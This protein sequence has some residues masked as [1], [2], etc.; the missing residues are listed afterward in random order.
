MRKRRD[1]NL[2]NFSFV[3]ILAT[4]VGVLLFILLMA[5][6]NQSGLAAHT[7]WTQQLEDAKAEARAATRA[8]RDAQA[9]YASARER[10]RQASTRTRPQAAALAR[11]AQRAADD[12]ARRAAANEQTRKRILA[13][14]RSLRQ[15][16]ADIVRLQK[17]TARPTQG[18]RLMLPVA[19]KATNKTAVHVD[20]Q[21]QGLV[22]IGSKVDAGRASRTL[23]PASRI[24][25]PRS[26]FGSL[27]DAMRPADQSGSG[28]ERVLVLWI[29]PDG[30]PTA[31]RAL[32]A[33]RRARVPVGWE[34]ADADWT[35]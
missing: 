14:K 32:R 7:F 23:C 31:D 34:P 12:N 13:L 33:A 18:K 9:N 19:D 5:I 22:I 28:P 1:V 15:L 21:R 8:A 29:R 17:T 35:F 10:A 24:L 20:C 2:F 3:D 26:A 11:Q 6:L 4:T 30:I 16:D 27:L 25:D